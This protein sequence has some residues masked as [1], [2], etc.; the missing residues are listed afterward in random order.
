MNRPYRLTPMH[1]WHQRHGAKMAEVAGWKRVVDYGDLKSEVAALNSSAGLSDATPISK[2]DVQGRQSGQVLDRF[3]KIPG[4][5][6]CAAAALSRNAAL[7]A[8]VARLTR[9]RFIV[10][11]GVEQNAQIYSSLRDAGS[12]D[13]C[14]H[15]TDL[16]SAY[17]ALQLIGPM[18]PKLLKKLGPA[19]IDSIKNDRCQQ[20]PLARVLAVLIRRDIRE[21]PGW[22]IMVSRDYGEYVWEC[23]LAAGH[24]FGIRPFGA[25]AEKV[26]M[27]AEAADVEVF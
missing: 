10:L 8:Y 7:S 5:G 13:D 12:D 23:V 14:V 26:L 27:D 18:S 4:I 17:A 21:V 25:Q 15:V 6:E 2:I 19:Q 1:E 11:G 3:T 22:L 24:E 20:S 16:T 9:D